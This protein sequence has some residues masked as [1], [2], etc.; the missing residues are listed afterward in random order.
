[1]IGYAS[2]IA[3]SAAQLAL[4]TGRRREWWERVQVDQLHAVV[5]AP[6]ADEVV[7]PDLQNVERS[8]GCRQRNRRSPLGE[9]DPSCDRGP[10]V[11]ERPDPQVAGLVYPDLI[12]Q[13]EAVA[14]V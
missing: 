6:R 12:D 3:A 1:L 10:I 5:V 14:G 2:S 11:I 8:W 13:G 4:F 7:R 9:D